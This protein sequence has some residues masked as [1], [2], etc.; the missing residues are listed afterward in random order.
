MERVFGPVLFEFGAVDAGT[1]RPDGVNG[2]GWETVPSG[3][4]SGRSEPLFGGWCVL[5]VRR[6]LFAAPVAVL[7]K[8]PLF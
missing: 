7:S 8:A 1:V 6:L 2:S 3:G 4:L 5:R